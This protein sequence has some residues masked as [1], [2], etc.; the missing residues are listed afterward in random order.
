MLSHLNTGKINELIK[1][2]V[3]KGFVLN[4]FADFLSGSSHQVIVKQAKV[5][6]LTELALCLHRSCFALWDNVMATTAKTATK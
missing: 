6:A 2:K 5:H 1:K 3:N 4:Q